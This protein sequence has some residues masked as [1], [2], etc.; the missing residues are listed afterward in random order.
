MN[1]FYWVGNYFVNFMWLWISI[2]LLYAIQRIVLWLMIDI[3]ELEIMLYNVKK[4][5]LR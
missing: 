2:P 5:V 1:W 4:E 3:Y